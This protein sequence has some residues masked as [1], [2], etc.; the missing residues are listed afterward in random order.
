MQVSKVYRVKIQ[1]RSDLEYH[2]VFE[3]DFFDK[4]YAEYVFK[5]K[6]EAL[7]LKMET[8]V[9]F[10]ELNVVLNTDG[11]YQEIRIIGEKKFPEPISLEYEKY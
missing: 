9:D 1:P 3:R 10:Q 11:S 8:G 5:I 4:E 2:T 7:G 6:K